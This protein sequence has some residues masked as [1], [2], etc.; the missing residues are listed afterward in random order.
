MN[1]HTFGPQDSPS[2]DEIEVRELYRQMLDGWN[3]RSAGAF[4]APIAED[5][6]LIGFDGS[7]L[8]G[9]S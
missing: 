2:P 9:S 1:S 7:Q 4:A 3:K 6:E 8:I 5:G